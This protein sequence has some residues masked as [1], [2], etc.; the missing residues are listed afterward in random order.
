[1]SKEDE[2][3]L[4]VYP[5]APEQYP[6]NLGLPKPPLRTKEAQET[7]KDAFEHALKYGATDYVGFIRDPRYV[8]ALNFAGGDDRRSPVYSAVYDLYK[9][10]T[11]NTTSAPQFAERLGAI[12]DEVEW[13]YGREVVAQM[14][15]AICFSHAMNFGERPVSETLRDLLEENTKLAP[16]FESFIKRFHLLSHKDVVQE[17]LPHSQRKH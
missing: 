6:P 17:R 4:P 10:N 1:M 2:D 11:L 5:P 15:N 12:F 8:P 14:G 7:L 13:N 9:D 3:N 16:H